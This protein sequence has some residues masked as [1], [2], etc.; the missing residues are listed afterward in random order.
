[1]LTIKYICFAIWNELV[2]FGSRYDVKDILIENLLNE[3]F[4]VNAL[5]CKQFSQ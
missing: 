2:E 4:Y 1:M 3:N 5:I